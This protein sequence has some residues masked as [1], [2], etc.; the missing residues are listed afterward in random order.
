LILS[1]NE[2]SD[3]LGSVIPISMNIKA[4]IEQAGIL[5]VTILI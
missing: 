5:L 4:T 2:E 1:K 3:I